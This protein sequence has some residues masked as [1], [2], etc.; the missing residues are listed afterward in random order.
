MGYFS[1]ITQIDHYLTYFT[2]TTSMRS[3]IDSYANVSIIPEIDLPNRVHLAAKL[4][5]FQNVFNSDLDVF[6]E[7]P[8]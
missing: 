7:N 6:H 4:V 5:H 3:E 1:K 8:M 2:L